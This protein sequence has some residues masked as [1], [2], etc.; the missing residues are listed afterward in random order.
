MEKILG[1]DTGTNSLGWAIVEKCDDGEFRLIDRGVNIFQEGVNIEKGGM[2]SSR[3]AERTCHKSARVRYYR[4]RLRKLRLLRVLSDNGLCPPLSADELSGWRLHKVYPKNELFMSWQS[5]DDKAGKNPYADR[6][7]CLHETLDLSDA[8]D[9]YTLG[10]ALYHMV[11]RRGFLSNRKDRSGDGE[12]GEV[13]AG[14]SRLTEEMR[15]AGFDYLGDYFFY[16][17]SRGEKIRNRYTARE[18]HYLREF[19]AICDRQ[20]LDAA[21]AA[22]LEKAIFFQRPLKSQKGLVGHCVFE[23]KKTRCPVSHPCFEEFRM[24]QF[25]N[26]IRVETSEGSGFRPLDSDE[27][28]K[29]CSMFY[30]KSKPTFS[31]EDIAKAVAGKGKYCFRGDSEEKPY[32][33]NYFSDTTVSGCPVT[34][35]LRDIFGD[36]WESA[37]GEVYTLAKGKKPEQIVNDVWH[38][39]FFFDDEDKLA[40]FARDRLQLSDEEARKFCEIRVP[41]DY[42]SLSLKAIKKILPYLRQGHVYSHAV[43]LASLG[44]VFPDYVRDVPQVRDTAVDEVVEEMKGY[45]YTSGAKTLTEHVAQ[46]LEGRYKV[47]KDEALKKLWHPSMTETYPR[48][49]PGSDGVCQLGSPRVESVRN[50]MAMRAMF[51]LRHL[52]NAL[53]RAGKIDRETVVHIEFARGL[54]DA[55]MRKAISETNKANEKRRE[56]AAKS[57]VSLYKEE[58]GLDITPT[59]AD[60]RKYLL[61]EEQGGIC[62]YTGTKIGITDFIG[63]HPKYDIEHTVP[64]SA[65]GDTTM[66]NLTLCDSDFNRKVKKNRMPSQLTGY[67]DAIMARIE[68]WKERADKLDKQIRALKIRSKMASTK[69][70]KDSAIAERHKCELE[71]N[72]WRGKYRRFTMTDVPEG[73]SRR[74]GTDI[75]VISKYACLYLKSVFPEVYTVKG[76]VTSDFRKLWGLQ[77]FYAKKE[78]ASHVHHCVDAVVIVCVGPGYYNKLTDYYSKEESHRLYGTERVHFAKPWPTFVEDVKR[79]QDEILVYHYTADNVSKRKCRVRYIETGDGNGTEKKREKVRDY[80]DTARGSLHKDTCY[81][82][83]E[84]DGEVKYVVRRELAMMTDADVKSVVDDTVREKIEAAVRKHGSLKKA[85]EAGI[86]MNE[87][88]RVPVRKVR[89]YAKT[90]V[91]PLHIRRQRDLSDKEYK[92]QYHVANDSNYMMAIYAGKDKRGKEKRDFR[93]VNMLDAAGYYGTGGGA[94][95]AASPVPERSASG[96]PLAFTLK[97]GTML[98]LYENDPAEVWADDARG[99]NRRLYK[100]TGMS[101]LTTGGYTYGRIVMVHHE[102]ARP[103]KDIK[104]KNVPFRQGD[105][106]H[107]SIMMLHTQLKALVQGYDFEIDEMGGIKYLNTGRQ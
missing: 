48:V 53:L 23:K 13:K 19:R 61:R 106:Y 43:I 95:A 54:N 78:R 69:E 73:F 2:E 101:T 51:R 31:F 46:Y 66:E 4:V 6:H 89:C 68:C 67:Y 9:R 76:V 102:E 80:M 87:E 72:Y 85:V 3:A 21:L 22:R 1:I 94:S 83:I 37:V 93:L 26:G 27:R 42:A 8:V 63:P 35:G 104:T 41:S 96:Y 91:S 40:G 107:P 60:I 74:Q 86:W 44:K 71:R 16:L 81:G 24:L 28:A 64:R 75:G 52:V 57:I 39:L 14:I 97:T 38:A 92:R 84:R 7:R 100:V 18:E 5:T 90:I 98:L 29:A 99:L 49:R 32:R 58:T 25:V 17:Y 34:A 70:A 45:D 77:D 79:I 11:Q 82:A 12:N 33:F 10:R 47:D 62:L 20:G 88:K 103:A 56:A 36:D 65:G 55:N 15:G 30:R 50:P 59:E 105:E